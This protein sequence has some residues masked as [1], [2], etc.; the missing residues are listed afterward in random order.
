M[1]PAAAAR[2]TAGSP[3][4]PKAQGALC[5]E[6]RGL[7][8]VSTEVGESVIGLIKVAGLG[9]LLPDARA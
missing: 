2:G 6:C 5:P 9:E 4:S 8:F 1:R 7:G 3:H